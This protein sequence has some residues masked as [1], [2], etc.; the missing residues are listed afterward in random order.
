MNEDLVPR[1]QFKKSPNSQRNP[2]VTN[3]VGDRPDKP[4]FLWW[5]VGWEWGLHISLVPLE[6]GRGFDPIHY[7]AVHI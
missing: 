6:A 3:P 4:Q 7:Y 2:I 1:H 5:R